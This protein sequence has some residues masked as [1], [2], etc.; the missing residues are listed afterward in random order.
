MPSGRVL[1]AFVKT[2]PR[3]GLLQRIFQAISFLVDRNLTNL[4]V[5]VPSGRRP[6]EGAGAIEA[7][8]FQPSQKEVVPMYRWK[9][10]RQP[11][12]RFALPARVRH[13]TGGVALAMPVADRRVYRRG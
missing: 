7:E 2:F 4:R 9:R 10:L 1:S 5:R 6:A 12:G 3:Y 11:D 13:L 8:G